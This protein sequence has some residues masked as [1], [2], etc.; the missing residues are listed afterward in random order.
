VR[1]APLVEARPGAEVLAN[2]VQAFLHLG[3]NG[4][5]TVTAI[6]VLVDGR[7]FVAADALLPHDGGT[8]GAVLWLRLVAVLGFALR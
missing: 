5:V 6:A 3:A 4:P 7:R 2:R 8:E 1:V